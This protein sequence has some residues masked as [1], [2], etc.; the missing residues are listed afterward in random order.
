MNKRLNYALWQIY[1]EFSNKG[2]MIISRAD[3]ERE[4]ERISIQFENEILG[5]S[6]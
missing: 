4:I 3:W 1:N 6:E 2:V 5:S